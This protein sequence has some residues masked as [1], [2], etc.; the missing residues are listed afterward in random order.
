L[1]FAG[2]SAAFAIGSGIAAYAFIVLF[3]T[4]LSLWR[5]RRNSG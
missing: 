2:E 3:Y 4:S 1:V 5:L